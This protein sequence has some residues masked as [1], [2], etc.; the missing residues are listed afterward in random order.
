MV[1]FNSIVMRQQRMIE[2]DIMKFWGI[3]LVVLGH[4]TN[5]YTPQG[6]VHPTIQSDSLAMVSTF[7]YSFHMPLFVFVSGC[8]CAFQIEV[9]QRKVSFVNLI[10]KKSKRLLIPYLVFGIL[11]IVLMIGCGFRD[12]MVDYAYNGVLLSKDSRHLWFVLMLFEVF[13]LFWCMNK[14]VE[15]LKLPKWSMLVISFACYLLADHLPYIFQISSAFRYFFWFTLGYVFL[16]YKNIVNIVYI[17]ISG[18]VILTLNMLFVNDMG[19]RIPLMATLTAFIG[20][21]VFYQISCDTKRVV[22]YRFY[23]MISKDSFGIYLYHVFF[24]YLLFYF[25]SDI[26]ISPYLLCPLAFVV[27]LALSVVMTELTRK[28]GL[29]VI[30]GEKIPYAE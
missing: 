23:Q 26:P 6:L 3:L 15:W 1:S 20:I 9:L 22:K 18:G 16:L 12:N 8:V 7:V 14:M 28:F 25:L 5:M 27:S 2:L 19:M 10:Q 4:I 30:I 17:Y 11:L 24:I 13:V 29:Q 21:M